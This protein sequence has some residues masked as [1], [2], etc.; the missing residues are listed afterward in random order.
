MDIDPISKIFKICWTDLH[1]LSVPVFTKNENILDFQ[2]VEGWK[3]ILV[4]KCVHEASYICLKYFADKYRVIRSRLNGN[5]Q[6]SRD[7]PRRVAIGPE[8]LISHFGIIKTC[9]TIINNWTKMS[10]FRSLLEPYWSPVEWSIF[11][12]SILIWCHPVNNMSGIDFERSPKKFLKWHQQEFQ[13]KALGQ[14][15]GKSSE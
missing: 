4:L 12:L 10:S 3:S 11:R 6:C 2:T 8:L 7:H 1:H 15:T 14:I 5:F 9:K 13:R